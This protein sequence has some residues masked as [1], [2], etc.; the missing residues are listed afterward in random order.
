MGKI[1]IYDFDGTL[2]PYSIPKFG[3]LEKCGFKD[4]T[5]SLEFLDLVKLNMKEDNS[6]LYDSFVKVLFNLIKENGFLLTE[7]NITFGYDNLQ[8]NK[9]VLEFF[10]ML[11]ESGVKNYLLSSGFKVCLEKTVISKY[12][13]KIYGTLFS[14]GENKEINGIADM[15][16]DLC[17]QDK[18][19]EILEKNNMKDTSEIIYIGDG[20]TDYYAMDYVKKNGGTSVLVYSDENDFIINQMEEKG[21][22]SVKFLADYSDD[23]DLTLFIKKVC[24]IN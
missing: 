4:G 20:L 19:K 12:F 5:I 1:I 8:Y 13:E 17:K 15:V 24:N 14:Y 16:S 21:V 22:V 11:Q 9:G 18:I 6:S 7:E 10:D 3:I 23:S 2:T